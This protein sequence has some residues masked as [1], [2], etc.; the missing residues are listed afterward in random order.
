MWVLS[1]HMYIYTYVCVCVCVRVGRK[2]FMR[3]KWLMRANSVHI[4]TSLINRSCVYVGIEC[5]HIYV[6][7]CV[8]VCA[9]VLAVNG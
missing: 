7:V 5:A 8:C 6:Y 9:C 1:V 3:C 2:W 4:Y